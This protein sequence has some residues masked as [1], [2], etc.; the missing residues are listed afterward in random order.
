MS[1]R[2]KILVSALVVV[3]LLT[4][5]ATATVMAQEDPT[6]TPQAEA[7]GLLARVAEIL[8]I[9]Q[10]ELVDAFRQAQ[11][12][13]RQEA[14][15]RFLNKAVENERITQEEADEIEEWREQK[16][17]ALESVQGFNERCRVRLQKPEALGLAQSFRERCQLRLHKLTD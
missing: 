11:Q 15:I 1:K 14:S 10:E 5:G 12:E 2:V 17:E 3:L 13:I 8:D 6:P 4:V 16:P 9:P 7:K